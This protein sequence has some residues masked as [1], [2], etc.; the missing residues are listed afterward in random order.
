MTGDGS[1]RG[2]GLSYGFLP[3]RALVK[4]A[5]AFLAAPLLVSGAVYIASGNKV[6]H[7]PYSL[8][9][10]A[11]I[12]DPVDNQQYA[13]LATSLYLD[14][15]GF[16]GIATT[17]TIPEVIPGDTLDQAVNTGV[18]DLVSAVESQYD[19]QAFDA[20]DPLYI[21]GYSQGAVVA[22][23]AEQQLANYG[24]A[25]DDLHFVLVGD[26]ASADGGFL[27]TFIDSLPESWRQ[28]TIDTLAAFGVGNEFGVVTPDNLYPTTVYSLSGDGWT[29]WDN[30]ANIA[31]MSTDHL[32]YL[33]LTPSEVSSATLTLADQMTDYYTI[34]SAAVDSVTALWNALE[35]AVSVF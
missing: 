23:L 16:D 30:G 17:L 27:N 1:N 32:E 35:M 6:D 25:P 15:S 33:G 20:T 5:G 34:N 10:G 22:S 4:T 3:T 12:I 18:Q 2:Y 19:N 28:F 14:P 13:D 11:L 8:T 9:S 7:S 24:I 26:S 31:G 29:S 21:F